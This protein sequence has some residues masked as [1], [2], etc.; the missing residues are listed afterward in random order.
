MRPN[1]TGSRCYT[2]CHSRN[3]CSSRWYRAGVEQHTN[4][5]EVDQTAALL[6]IVDAFGEGSE[7]VG[8]SV[9]AAD[10]EVLISAVGGDGVEGGIVVSLDDLTDKRD[11]IGK[12]G[13][14]DIEMIQ[15]IPKSL[16]GDDLT[17]F[18]HSAQTLQIARSIEGRVGRLGE[19]DLGKMRGGH[20]GHGR[21]GNAG[22]GISI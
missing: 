21:R 2:S 11:D 7:E 15:G 22:L 12:L 18:T 13:D 20:G 8:D 4:E 10:A 19:V 16:V 1:T 9:T 5:E 17:T 3:S 6:S 14:V